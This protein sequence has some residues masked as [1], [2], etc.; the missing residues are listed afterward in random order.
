MKKAL[1][2]I[3]FISCAVL[4]A[5]PVQALIVL[6]PPRAGHATTLLNSGKVLITGGVNESATLNSAL[7][8]DPATGAFEP[9]GNMTAPRA[10]HTATQLHE[11]RFH[12]QGRLQ[13]TVA[14]ETAVL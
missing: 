1:F 11:G 4:G 9:T 2:L 12:I 10:D 5:S 6:N 3:L 13:G 14:L 7:L 8:Y